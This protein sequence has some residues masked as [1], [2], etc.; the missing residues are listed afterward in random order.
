MIERPGMLSSMAFFDPSRS[1]R[2][3]GSTTASATAEMLVP[4]WERV[5]GRP[6]VGIEDNFFDAGGNVQLADLLF[7][8][9]ARE[10]GRDLPSAIIFHAPTIAA[11]AY[12]LEQST[13]PRFSPFIPLKKGKRQPPILMAH[14]LGGR[15]RFTELAKHIH[16]DHPIYGIQAKGIDGREEPFDRIEDMAHFYLAALNELQPQGP[17]ILIGYSFGGLVALEMAQRLS[18]DGRKIG[19]LALIDAYPYPRYMS[20][21]QR[22][23]LGLQRSRSRVSK[24]RQQPFRESVSYLLDG[25]KRRL[26]IAEAPPPDALIEGSCLSLAQTTLQV[27]AKAYLALA[28]YRPRP[29]GGK[30]KFVKS[31]GD[32]FFPGDPV[33]VWTDLAPDFEVETVPGNHLDM[34]TTQFEGLAAVLTRYLQEALPGE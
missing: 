10:S 2:S 7:A 6:S 24:I 19:L 30:I 25:V 4:I 27:K 26:G 31:E 5:L 9:I 29:Y 12:L 28:S 15:A 16:T 1:G 20:A 23:R 8:E 3:M 17:Y 32:T 33:P 13:L 34:V 18:E 21:R 22:L 14:G 11:L